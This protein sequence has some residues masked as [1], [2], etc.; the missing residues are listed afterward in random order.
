LAAPVRPVRAGPMGVFAR[1]AGKTGQRMCDM[2]PER[3]R[4]V[5]ETWKRFEPRAAEHARY[6]YDKLFELDPETVGMFDRAKMDLQ[7]HRL[8][9]SLGMLIA[10]LDDPEQLVTDLVTLGRRHVAYGVRDSDYSA[11]GIALLWTLEKA[12]GPEFTPEARAAWTEA[13]QAIASVMRRVSTVVT[14]DHQAI[15]R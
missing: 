4:I 9:E 8:M 12:L 6:F 2:T 7:R 13:Y 1:C 14:G 15:P 10:E 5:R 3:L 11:A